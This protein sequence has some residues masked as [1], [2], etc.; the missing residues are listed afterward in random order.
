[1]CKRLSRPTGQP[2]EDSTPGKNGQSVL[3]G[4]D[5]EAKRLSQQQQ[6]I[7]LAYQR[8]VAERDTALQGLQLRVI[9]LER[10]LASAHQ[11]GLPPIEAYPIGGTKNC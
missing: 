6:E 7:L 1:M 8:A 4:E 9:E 3:V 10:Q 2:E 11:N 5:E